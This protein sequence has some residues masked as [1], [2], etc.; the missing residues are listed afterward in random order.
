MLRRAA[1]LTLALPLPTAALAGGADPLRVGP[2]LTPPPLMAPVREVALAA[3]PDGTLHLGAVVDSGRFSSGRGTFTGRVVRVWRSQ[4][5]AW[6]PL[7]DVL[8]YRQPRPASNLNLVL[9][10]QGR[11]A[12]VWNENYGDNDVVEL[13]AWREGQGWTDWAGRYLGDD[14]PYAARTRAVAAW[15]G[16]IVLA[17]GEYLRKP[18]GSQLTVRRWDPA[19]KSWVRGPAFND[20]R[21]FSRT[22]AL[23][24]T[25][26]GQPVVAWLQGE[27]TESRVLAARWTGARWQPLG[28]ALN[29]Q[30]AYVASTRMV[31]DGQDRPTVAWLQQVQ[32]QDTLL[33][34]R[35]DG[36]RWVPM[37]GALSRLY[38]S[39]PALATDPAGHAVLA[40]VEERLSDGL[41][42]IHAARWDGRAWAAWPVLN[43]SLKRDARSP[44]VAVDRQGRVTVAWREDVGGRYTVQVQR[45]R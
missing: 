20:I 27:V 11:P 15:Q 26:S 33:A 10:E 34:T 4:G 2:A 29:A 25:R 1:L 18:D 40:W 38:A 12:A 42:Q 7:G 35:W 8:N 3:A 32:G 17:W 19:Q 36:A 28:G 39:A 21:T 30:P 22:P 5:G 37:G 45:L 14:L 41:G 24:L 43:R 44:A 31:L 16:E 9:D 6:Q 23:A 13:R